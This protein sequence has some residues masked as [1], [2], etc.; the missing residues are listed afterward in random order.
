M[1][2]QVFSFHLLFTHLEYCHDGRMSS[3]NE[4]AQQIFYRHF[5]EKNV[6]AEVATD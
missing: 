1:F 2:E 3:S 4:F 6:L 5:E